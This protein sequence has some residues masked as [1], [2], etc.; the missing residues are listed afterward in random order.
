MR[1][2]RWITDATDAHS[3]YVTLISIPLQKWLRER[4]STLYYMYTAY[5]F[6]NNRHAH[7]CLCCQV[8]SQAHD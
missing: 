8:L 2:A 4:L 3:E 5:I 7:M 1:I 6:K